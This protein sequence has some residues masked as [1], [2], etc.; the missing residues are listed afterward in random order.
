MWG[1]LKD[2]LGF[3]GPSGVLCRPLV[4]MVI[5]KMYWFCDGGFTLGL[6]MVNTIPLLF[7]F[8]VVPAIC[9]VSDPSQKAGSGAE[10]GR[11]ALEGR[12][13]KRC[14]VGKVGGLSA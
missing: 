1:L 2:S 14:K 12:N 13:G 6:N 7:L 9:G 5:P 4:P 3:H 8:K 11:K 10:P